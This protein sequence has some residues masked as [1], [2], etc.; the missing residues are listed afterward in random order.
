MSDPKKDA[1]AAQRGR[2][3]ADEVI[4]ERNSDM[5]GATETFLLVERTFRLA[6]PLP[7]PRERRDALGPERP[8]GVLVAEGDSWFDYPRADILTI[9]GD[10]FGFE[11]ETVARRGDRVEDMAY[12]N[13]QLSAFTLRIE[14][15]LRRGDVPRAVLLSGGGNDI[16]GPELAYILNHA[17]SPSPGLN[18]A[19]LEGV[20]NE[21]LRHSYIT[22]ISAVTAVCEERIGRRLP[23]IV[24]GY[25]YAVPDGRGFIG[26]W[27][28][29]PGPW[30]E[31]SLR[32]KGYAPGQTRRRLI[33]EL[34]DTFNT[35][36]EDLTSGDMMSHVSYVNL[37]NTLRNEASVYKKWWANEL[38]PTRAGFLLVASRFAEAIERGVTT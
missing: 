34:I 31:P 12:S 35:M 24:H 11:I 19:V 32:E 7:V 1:K 2:Q 33:R 13:G 6:P 9:L 26:G 25:D 20:I 18:K 3:Q 17:D 16:A 10:R 28:P 27:G 36:L 15:V 37:R 30:L 22:M 23:I 21:R 14:A 29:L 4:R 5:A 8:N 38:H